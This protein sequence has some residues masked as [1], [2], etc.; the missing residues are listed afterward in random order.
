MLEEL[1]NLG[2]RLFLSQTQDWNAGDINSTQASKT[3]L[4][5]KENGEQD[6]NTC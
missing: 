2:N 3:T 4:R 1:K 6:F 5:M